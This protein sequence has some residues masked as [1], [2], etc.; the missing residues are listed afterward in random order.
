MIPMGA[1]GWT[2]VEF[3]YHETDRDVLILAADGGLNAETAEQFVRQL[4]RLIAGGVSK[5]IVDCSNLDYVSSYG[6]SILVR[7]HHNLARHGGD[8]KL[9]NIKSNV[10][11]LLSL[12]R[13]DGVLDI[14]PDVNRARLAFRPPD[15][16]ARP[17][18]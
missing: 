2:R 8:V 3:Y 18:D 16:T 5:V 6:V 15:A 11:S 10:V 9:A 1:G 12:L 13:I 4:E 14:Y 17:G 7:L